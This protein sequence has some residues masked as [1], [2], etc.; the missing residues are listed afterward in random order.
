M[1]RPV[2]SPVH[3]RTSTSVEVSKN[4]HLQRS[5]SLCLLALFAEEGSQG[6]DAAPE[7]LVHTNAEPDPARQSRTNLFT[8]IATIEKQKH[9]VVILVPNCTTH[10]LIHRTHAHVE[11]ELTT[12][13]TRIRCRL[14]MPHIG[15]A[16][17]QFLAFGVGK[18]QSDHGNTARKV[19]LEVDAL[20]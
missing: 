15:Y 10:R 4:G 13:V 1:I 5:N 16:F 3:D 19:V 11:I 7:M 20:G 18:R 8:S 14:A 9:S 17:R 2:R 6:T 12:A